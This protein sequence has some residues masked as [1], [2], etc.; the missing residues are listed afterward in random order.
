M[1]P[2]G[3]WLTWR[4]ARTAAMPLLAFAV[5]SCTAADAPAYAGAAAQCVEAILPLVGKAIA[6][7]SAGGVAPVDVDAGR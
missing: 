7:A 3:Q 1:S 5:G 6:S 2:L 4:R